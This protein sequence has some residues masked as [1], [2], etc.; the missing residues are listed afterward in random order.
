MRTRTSLLA[1]LCLFAVPALAQ[2]PTSAVPAKPVPHVAPASSAKQTRPSRAARPSSHPSPAAAAK[3]D[4]A[5][6]AAIRHLMDITQTSKL[7][8]NLATY[9]NN[10]VK[11]V[12][13]HNLQPDRLS[14]FMTAFNQKFRAGAPSSAITDAMVPIYAQAFSM[15][16]IQGLVRFYQSPLGQHVVK[17]LPQVLA[18]SQHAG[19]QIDQKVAINV[20]RSMSDDYPE[21]KHMLP[22]ANGRPSPGAGAAPQKS[23]APGARKP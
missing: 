16:E 9:I 5:K 1:A 7:G 19:L 2:P 21:L 20:L 3:I 23:P 18:E 4:P 6:E 12:M 17:V 10:Q 13:S 14:K 8:D 15:D 11:T 22:G